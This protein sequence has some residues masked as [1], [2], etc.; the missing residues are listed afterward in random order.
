MTQ[1]NIK[2]PKL[3]GSLKLPPPRLYKT[4]AIGAVGGA[5][6]FHFRLPLAWMLGAMV[7]CTIA[8]LS[9]VKLLVPGTLRSVMVSVLGV[10]LGSTFTPEVIEKASQW[11]FTILSL[12]LYI[13]VLTG[14]LYLYFSRFQKFDPVTA[15]FSATPGGLNEMVIAGGAMG[16]DER[17]IALVHG[18]RVL[19]VVMVIPFWFRYTEGERAITTAVG[20]SIAGTSLID[21]GVLV[22]CAVT[23]VLLGRLVRLPAYRIV[24]P[25]LVSAGV[26]IAGITSS[27]PPWEIVAVAQVVVGSSVGARFSGIPL[28]RVLKTIA[29]SAGATAVMLATSVLFA[30]ALSKITDISMAPIVLAFSPGGLAEMSLIALSLGIET[31][32]V[33]THHVSRIAM[34]V[35][36]APLVFKALG[37]KA[38]KRE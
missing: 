20:P 6:F 24:G 3:T 22:T 2:P 37:V 27:S 21:I 10:L 11:P 30:L 35:I 38:K 5:I 16:G 28:E 8:S 32:F 29:A 25:M 14:L 33:A 15:Y 9:G 34:I 26:H 12:A 1:S 36:A 18:A 4:L 7:I 13:V 19:L 17:T 23:G 31:A